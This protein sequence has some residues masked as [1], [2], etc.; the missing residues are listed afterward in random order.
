MLL[1]A[2]GA[3]IGF[4]FLIT[5]IALVAG[6]SPTAG[7]EAT[8]S[9]I[10]PPSAR[11]TAARP[12]ATSQQ[13]TAASSTT[14][15]TTKPSTTKPT[16]TKPTTTKPTTTK[17]TTSKPSTKD[18]RGAHGNTAHGAR[19]NPLYFYSP[20][21][22]GPCPTPRITT[23]LSLAQNEKIYARALA[24]APKVWQH[25]FSYAETPLPKVGLKFFRGK[26][27]TPCG[28]MTENRFPG[29]YCSSSETIYIG[30]NQLKNFSYPRIGMTSYAFHEFSHH[31]QFSSGI[32]SAAYT[33]EESQLQISR[34][35]ELQ[36]DCLM[37]VAMRNSRGIGFSDSDMAD[38]VQWRMQVGEEV[39]GSGKNQVYWIRKGIA[40]GKISTCNTFVA[41]KKRVS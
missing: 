25:P 17:P 9:P 29:F 33:S 23:D 14:K 35:V 28:T 16:T 30:R 39:H 27:T 6:G 21:R 10:P 26:V 19:K 13:P 15:P 36:A 7:P 20:G 37:G 34:R 3:V 41:P 4:G 38:L 5:V 31:V 2:V 18:K 12:T 32:L 1:L 11:T 24:C 8:P 40:A 22:G